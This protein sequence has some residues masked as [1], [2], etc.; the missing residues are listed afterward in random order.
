MG[1]LHPT[2]LV[3][4]MAGDELRPLTRWCRTCGRLVHGQYLGLTPAGAEPCGRY[5]EPG[6]WGVHHAVGAQ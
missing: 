1:D 3:L 6:V 5:A 4:R 2:H